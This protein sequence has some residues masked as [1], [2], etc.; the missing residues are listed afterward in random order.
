[1]KLNLLYDLVELKH[2]HYNLVELEHWYYN[3]VNFTP[4]LKL[5]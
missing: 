4:C 2:W 5:I 1:M 3:L